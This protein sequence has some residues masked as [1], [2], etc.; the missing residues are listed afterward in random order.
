MFHFLPLLSLV[1]LMSIGCSPAQHAPKNSPLYYRGYSAA[2]LA[3]A[4]MP[5]TGPDINR[6]TPRE[7]ETRP[8]ASTPADEQDLP[9][10][11]PPAPVETPPPPEPPAA[12]EKPAEPEKVAESPPV[13]EPTPA[14]EP[15]PLVEPPEP[16]P[17]KFVPQEAP[18]TSKRQLLYLGGKWCGPCR[19]A[20]PNVEKFVRARSLVSRQFGEA[21]AD[22]AD[23]VFVEVTPN[24]LLQGS[25]QAP[26]VPAGSLPAAVLVDA[27]CKELSR[28]S[29]V[30]SFDQI[31]ALWLDGPK[32]EH[33]LNG[34]P[35]DGP[36]FASNA[37]GAGVNVEWGKL[38]GTAKLTTTRPEDVIIPIPEMGELVIPKSLSVTA[39]PWEEGTR[40]AV[41][42]G[43]PCP[44]VKSRWLGN[45]YPVPILAVAVSPKR[46]IVELRG[47]KDVEINLRG[48]G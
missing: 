40:V 30:S 8:Q 9:Q 36:R 4:S 26:P 38:L 3:F 25:G 6:P 29:G 18:P 37:S 5:S 11:E 24:G 20:K 2:A 46:A 16:V 31:E 41:D 14:A 1:A 27:D 10:A 23:V 17:P 32:R 7:P 42:A 34:L 44:Y 35:V 22:A 13:P 47:W 48:G 43:T 21:G 28:I 33:N 12:E 15:P 39:L 19:V 45:L